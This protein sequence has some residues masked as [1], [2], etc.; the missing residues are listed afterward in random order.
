MKN[1]KLLFSVDFTQVK[2]KAAQEK[3]QAT[4]VKKANDF[5]T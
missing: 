2:Q 3:K 5:Y 4:E 1:T